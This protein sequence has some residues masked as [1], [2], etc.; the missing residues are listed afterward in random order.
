MSNHWTVYCNRFALMIGDLNNYHGPAEPVK[1]GNSGELHA[2]LTAFIGGSK[3]ND[4]FVHG[5][6]EE[7]LIHDFKRYF[8]IHEAAGGLV[9]NSRREYLFIKRFGI[10]DLPKGKIEQDETPAEAALRE[11][12]EE[13]GVAPLQVVSELPATYHIY[14]LK[15][16][17][18]LKR[19]RWFRMDTGFSGPPVPEMEEDI[20]EASW[21]KTEEARQAL[22]GSYRSLADTLGPFIND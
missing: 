4:V 17:T 2:L 12:T 10:W 6:R 11:V 9:R 5:Y 3:E 22:K 7:S 21:L 1:V 15:K 20:T 14:Q 16:S 13:T 8:A 18:V 19:T